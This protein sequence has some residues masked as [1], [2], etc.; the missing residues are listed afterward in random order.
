MLEN[1]QPSNAIRIL[2]RC[3]SDDYIVETIENDTAFPVTEAGCVKFRVTGAKYCAVFVMSESF[4]APLHTGIIISDAMDFP[5][6]DY[7]PN[8]LRLE[9]VDVGRGSYELL[10]FCFNEAPVDGGRVVPSFTSAKMLPG[11]PRMKVGD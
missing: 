10:F 1:I 6:E 5:E 8:V 3:K 11:G 7:G 9:D 2:V 4:D